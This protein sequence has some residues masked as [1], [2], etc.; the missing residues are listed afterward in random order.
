MASDLECSCSFCPCART[1]NNLFWVWSSGG[2]Q[3]PRPRSE[4]QDQTVFCLRHQPP[5][6][7]SWVPSTDSQTP[8]LHSDPADPSASH[9]GRVGQRLTCNLNNS[10]RFF[11]F[12]TFK[13][14]HEI[15]DRPSRVQ[16]AMDEWKEES[17][18]RNRFSWIGVQRHN[19]ITCTETHC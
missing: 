6:M 18:A 16:D 14:S 12:I 10:V 9:D 11:Q 4:W 3:P 17:V 2:M 13:S 7:Q 15:I 5:T 19:F 8:P 1:H